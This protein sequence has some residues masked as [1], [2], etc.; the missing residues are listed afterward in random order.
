MKRLIYIVLTIVILAGAVYFY[1]QWRA[2][3][4]VSSLSSLQTTPAGR[5]Q[6]TASIGATGQ[7]RSKQSASLAWKTSGTVDNVL[8]TVGDAVKV[9][10]KLAELSQ[11]SLPQAVI[12]AQADLESAQKALDDLYTNAETA[13]VQTLQSI[14]EYTRAV[15]DA[16]YQLDNFTVP[17]EQARLDPIQAFD[18]LKQRLDVA[19]LAFE[20]YKFY[21]SGD[22]T[23]TDLKETLDLAQ[24]DFNIAVKRLDYEY[25]LQIANANLEKARSDYDRYQGGPDPAEVVA[26]EARIAAAQ[27]TLSQAWIEAPFE[28]TLTLAL[29]QAGDQV[30]PGVSAFRLDDLSSLMV[31]LAVS[32]IDINEIEFGQDVSL[33]FDAIRARDYHGVVVSV[34]RVG[35]SDQ[36]VV[37]FIVTVQLT[38]PDEQVKPGMTA[39]VNIV[40]NEMEDVLL[41]PNRA[42]RFQEG[43]QVV[44]LLRENQIIP[45]QI[46]L[47]ASS[48]TDSQ[49]VE[50]DLNVGDLIIL[51][52]PTEFESNGPP[53]FVRRGGG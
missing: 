35:T 45:V 16:Q 51:N 41:V 2:R 14:S 13:R 33:T 27:A 1:T 18:T 10:D 11:T 4:Q 24:A 21:P 36:G 22:A 23:R 47:G 30:A 46:K 9:G 53:P 7:V 19:R 32:E 29:P 34:D 52:P 48:E 25:A 5:G 43:S 6:L 12:L 8:Y 31:D 15:K 49:V 17:A 3:Q 39:A 38:D 28:G 44:F 50:G 37:D 42:V 40:V 20:P 26:A